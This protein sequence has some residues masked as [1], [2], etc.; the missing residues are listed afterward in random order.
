MHLRHVKMDSSADLRHVKSLLKHLVSTPQALTVG[1]VSPHL[2]WM[3]GISLTLNE[4][5]SGRL[6]REKCLF[7]TGKSSL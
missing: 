5:Q 3:V 7:F 1:T 6:V 2:G 4:A